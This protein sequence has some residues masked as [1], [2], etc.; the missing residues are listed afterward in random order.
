M[1]ALLMRRQRE[2]SLTPSDVERIRRN[3]LAHVRTQ[4]TLVELETNVLSAARKILAKYP[5]RTLDAIQLAS[6]LQATRTLSINLTFVSADARLLS[7]AS[8]EGL[9]IDD[10]NAYP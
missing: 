2:A 7:A 10:P 8:A 9:G 3:F 1:I 6:A 5:L 4:Y